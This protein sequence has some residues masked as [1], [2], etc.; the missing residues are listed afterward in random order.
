MTVKSAKW[1][2]SLVTNPDYGALATAVSVGLRLLQEGGSPSWA[3]FVDPNDSTFRDKALKKVH[4]TL[5]QG[6]L[7]DRFPEVLTWL[8]RVPKE[9]GG[10][11]ATSIAICPNCEQF[12]IVVG[13]GP[14]TCKVTQGCRNIAD[15]SDSEG[16]KRVTPFVV[17]AAVRQKSRETPLTPISGFLPTDTVNTV[18]SVESGGVVPVHQVSTDSGP[19][20]ED[21]GIIRPT[22]I[23]FTT[24]EDEEDEEEGSVAVA[25]P[26]E[27][28]VEP[29]PALESVVVSVDEEDLTDDW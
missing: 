26:A 18:N 16:K 12:T 8:A 9:G 27:Q 1:R 25:A 3:H 5:E 23:D 24:L 21:D 15:D 19:V 29:E 4:V 28:I 2:P 14:R 7:L 13:V 11:A 17:K 10:T 6:R 20:V 22:F